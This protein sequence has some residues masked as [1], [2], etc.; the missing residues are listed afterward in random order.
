MRMRTTAPLLLLLTLFL[1][2][3]SPRRAEALDPS[4]LPQVGY[5]PSG[6]AYWDSPFFGN[7]LY[8]GGF[9]MEFA[10]FQWG[11]TIPS[12]NTAQFAP[13]GAPLYTNAGLNLRALTYGL[14]TQYGDRPATWPNRGVLATGHVVLTWQGNADI[15]LNGAFQAGESSGAATGQLLNGRR[16][17]L[18]TGN[19]TVGS[20]EIYGI[21]A[22]NP[23]TNIKVWLPDPADPEHASL[24]GRLFHP[25]FLARLADANWGFLRFMNMTNTNGNPE[26]DWVDRRLPSHLFMTGVLNPRAPATG[27]PGNRETGMAWELAVALCNESGKD[28]WINIPH[29]AT[30]DYIRRLARLIRY[31]SD[32]TNPYS[33]TVATPVWAPLAPGRRVYIEYS[34][35]IWSSG[36]SFPQGDWA[37]EQ[38]TA[39]GITKA[40]FNA[41]RFCQA[42]SL[43]QDEFSGESNRLVRVAAVFTAADWYTN[44]FL[45]EMAT[46]GPTLSP[47]TEPDVIAAT[48][49]FGNGIQDWAFDKALA[50]AGTA[51]P[52]FLTTQTFDA[53]GGNMRPVC[54]PATDPYWTSPT[55][56][57]QLNATFDEWRYRMLSGDARE[58]A[59]PDAVGI[60][61]GFDNWLHD[62]A[63]TTFPTPKP[64]VAYEGGPSLYTDNRDGGDARDDG[65]TMF[66]EALNRHPRMAEIY[67]IHLNMAKS[68]GL[69]SHSMFTDSGTWGKYG[70]WGHLEFLAQAPASAPKY[71]FLLDW[72]VEQASIRHPDT[73]AGTAPGF[74]TGHHL[75]IA[76]FGQPYSADITVS[77]GDGARTIS[78]LGESFVSGLAFD[79]VPADPDLVRVA[80]TPTASGNSFVYLRVIDADG[81]P[82]W[83]TFTVKTV[84]G[85]STILEA[86]LEGTNL[87]QNAAWNAAYILA[88]TLTYSGIGRGTGIIA[89]TGSNAYIWSVNAPANEVD[90]TLALAIAEQEYLALTITPPTGSVLNLAGHTVRFTIRRIDYHAPRRYAVLT[91][92]GGFTEPAAVYTT[93]RDGSADDLE[94]SF[95]LPNTAAYNGIT[96]PFE[97][98][99]YGFSG[100]YGG[101]K[102]S[103]VAFRLDG[104]IAPLTAGLNGWSTL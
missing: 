78:K 56:Q 87:A 31:G 49:Y 53:G 94:Y 3:F 50:Q 58:G 62:A 99:L 34:N 42:W 2:A 69:W 35:E 5:H 79:D 13:N 47:A 59:G 85:P 48:T 10:P 101:H 57:A 55:L 64:I 18:Y 89:Q 65:I 68:K 61:G 37:Q 20:V 40:Q 93:S 66:M 102:T 28:M 100:Q 73:P 39:L 75:P 104:V 86:N 36:Y 54:V 41:R 77:G 15:R 80:G 1:S 29:L 70:Q 84:G 26:Q 25:T 30:D 82:A 19:N 90:S 24:E 81:D 60:G 76:V 52:W 9:W 32:G 103:L 63:N 74:V 96:A 11:S 67:R 38:A 98:R 17:Y 27:S 95:T 51:A 33:S 46:Y 14:H 71:Q 23:V 45:Q 83:R 4:T 43:F 12:W 92:V 91:S 7:A 22:G 16:V 88:P 6:I 8:N 72:M 21:D 44:P 97:L